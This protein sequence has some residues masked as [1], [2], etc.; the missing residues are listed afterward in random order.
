M[1]REVIKMNQMS[2]KEI[3]FVKLNMREG[4][5]SK[6]EIEEPLKQMDE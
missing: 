5:K 2:P 3:M 4:F 6:K 1:T